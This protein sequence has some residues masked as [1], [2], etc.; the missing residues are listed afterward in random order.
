MPEKNKPSFRP[1]FRPQDS[2][3]GA[4]LVGLTS[5]LVY[6]FWRIQRYT[7]RLFR[8]PPFIDNYILINVTTEEAIRAH[9]YEIAVNNLRG[10]IETR[11]LSDGTEKLGV[12]SFSFQYSWVA[13]WTPC[14]F[15]T[16]AVFTSSIE[17]K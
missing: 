9:G 3:L 15:S 6:A 12:A 4:L 17:M 14:R 13:P 16:P 2:L 8:Q 5:L 7:R 10:G 1:R 11:H